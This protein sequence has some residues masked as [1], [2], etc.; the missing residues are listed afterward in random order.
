MMRQVARLRELQGNEK[1]AQDLRQL[2]AE[3]AAQ[4]IDVMY[5]KGKGYFNVISPVSAPNPSQSQVKVQV[6]EMRH[7]VDMFSVTFG[8]C[9][10][11]KNARC[12][13][14]D[15]DGMR[16][17]VANWYLAESVT[18]TWIRATSPRCNC[19]N[20]R[21]VLVDTV[22]G[23]VKVGPSEQTT[24]AVSASASASAAGNGDNASYPAF[25]TCAAGRP[26]HGSNGAY[27]A[28]PAFATEA[29]CYLQHNNCTAA[30]G[31]MARFAATTAEGP[32]GQAR[33]VPQLSTPPY[34]PFDELAFKP[35]AVYNRYVGIEGG[36]FFDS[37]LRGFFGYHPDMQWPDLGPEPSAT[38]VNS[39]LTG[40]L[41]DPTTDRGFQGSLSNL[42]T[43]L[44]DVTVSSTAQGLSIKLQ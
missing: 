29:L 14:D 37:I 23:K 13:F 32:F 36:A 10:G 39:A 18:S 20:T 17:E 11:T 16:E 7:V 19:S 15:H 1:M 31:V 22:T 33:Q 3:M 38:A 27:P 25:V 26:D 21:E 12:D 34:T 5:E 24:T 8:M 28:W 35:V 4:T 6:N 2:S 30:L 9:G 44:G 41:F 43:P 42:R 40:M